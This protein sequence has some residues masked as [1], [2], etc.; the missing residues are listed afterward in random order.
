[1]FSRIGEVS[2]GVGGIML[3]R[4]IPAVNGS[5]RSGLTGA[6]VGEVKRPTALALD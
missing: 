3:A 1:V 4:R 6:H 2:S 5:R